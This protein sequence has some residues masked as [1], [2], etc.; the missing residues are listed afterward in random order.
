MDS[1][2]GAQFKLDE[3]A[4]EVNLDPCTKPMVVRLVWFCFVGE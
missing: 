3:F 2:A 1:F 4:L